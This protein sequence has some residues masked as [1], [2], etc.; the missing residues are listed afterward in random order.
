M[1][2]KYDYGY[3][4][5]GWSFD[6]VFVSML[7]RI[8]AKGI[9]NHPRGFSCKEIIAPQFILNVGKNNTVTKLRSRKLNHAFGVV[10]MFTYLSQVSMPGVLIAYNKNMA[11]F[12]NEKLGDFDAPYGK[13]IAKHGQLEYCYQELKRDSDSRRAVIMI[14]QPEDCHET[15]DSAC[16]LSL[17]FLIR[18]G[19]LDLIATMRSNDII[20]GTC[21]D[22]P[23]FTFL[24]QVMAFWLGVKTGKYIH[25]PGS[26]HYY[27][28]FVPMVDAL[29]S[30][31]DQDHDELDEVKRPVW[32]IPH[33]DT[34]TM[35]DFF[36]RQEEIIR[37]G[38]D[39]ER[40]HST[41]CIEGYLDILAGYWA[42]KKRNA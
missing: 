26:L 10:E 25:Q 4:D 35:L 16:T 40:E 32:D 34:T 2:I 7:K 21:Y 23:A 36:W 41:T 14:H 33:D 27:Q 11:K 19:K 30:E 5:E 29:I 9:W 28:E 38:L 18:E 13:R 20:L 37:K 8:Q 17:Q 31:Y 6:D 12:L 3:Q 39:T 1:E 22:I 42:R 24:Q 15:K